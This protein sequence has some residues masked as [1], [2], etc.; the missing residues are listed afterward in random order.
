MLQM[1][2]LEVEVQCQLEELVELVELEL[3]VLPDQVMEETV[4]KM[5]L[6]LRMAIILQIY[7]A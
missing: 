3:K 2:L 1:V 6:L 5:V 4:D 7:K